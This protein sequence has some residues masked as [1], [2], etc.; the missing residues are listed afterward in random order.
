V[1]GDGRVVDYGKSWQSRSLWRGGVIRAWDIEREIDRHGN[2][3]RYFYETHV[4]QDTGSTREKIPSRIE[5]TGHIDASGA[6]A[7]A[8]SG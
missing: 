4:N 3:I 8:T 1:G 6:E 5:Y 2:T 7:P